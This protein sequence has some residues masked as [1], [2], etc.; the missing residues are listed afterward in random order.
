MNLDLLFSPSGPRP[1]SD[2]SPPG[3]LRLL[4]LA[5]HPDDFDSIAVTLDSLAG[6][7]HSLEVVVARTG[8]GVD[9]SYRPGLT[10]AQKADV[11]E[12]EQR[13]SAGFFGLPGE[14]LEFVALE[15]D[16]EDQMIES[17]AN[18]AVIAEI[19]SVRTP[20]VVFMPHRDDSNSAHRAMY[21]MFAAIA[22]CSQRRMAALLN[23]DP[24]TVAMRMDIYTPFDRDKA[25]WKAR[26]LRFHDSQ[27]RRNLA[28]RGAGFDE[29]ILAVNRLTARE[30][31]LNDEY[32]EAFEVEIF[33]GNPVR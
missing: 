23:R 13:D 16:C 20:D 31:A 18:R 3:G 24:K 33:G 6:K 11:R 19:V 25:D 10:L 1:I 27:H 14:R 5:P 22:R 32:A 21:S 28:S 8:S 4:V 9:D 2:L 26:L 7:G 12:R 29:R 30:L 15:N 17:R